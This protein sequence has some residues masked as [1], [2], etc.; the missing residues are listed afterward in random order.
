MVDAF[1][2]VITKLADM[3]AFK[4]LFPFILTT[5][6]FYGLLRK[7]KLF[8]VTRKQKNEKGE[9]KDVEVSTGV[10]AIIA[11]TA[12]F[13]VWAYPIL[14]G[15][16]FQQ[17]MSAFFLQG[18][19]VTLIFMVALLI[20]SMFVPPDVT[21]QMHE[22]FKGNNKLMIFLIIAV[23]ILVI[24]FITSGLI[25]FI[26]GPVFEKINLSDGLMTIVVLALLIVPMIFIFKS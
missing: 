26:V 22:M 20:L 3:G 17:Q 11:I 5:T 13:M 21:A 1:T 7:S 24:V 18:T 19:I 15:I 16:D 9:E 10:N 6:I 14:Q 25:N 12:G 2:L 4:F 8:S 23:V